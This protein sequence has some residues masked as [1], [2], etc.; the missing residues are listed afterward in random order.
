MRVLLEWTDPNTGSRCDILAED[1]SF[2]DRMTPLHKATSG[3]RFLGVQLLL[4]ALKSRSLLEDGLAALDANGMTPLELARK[5]ALKQEEER[6]GVR[7]WDAIAGGPAD[8]ERCAKILQVASSSG[9]AVISLQNTLPSHLSG[10]KNSACFDC[11][12]DDGKCKTASWEAAFRSALA[13][14]AELMESQAKSVESTTAPSMVSENIGSCSP[15]SENSA[16]RTKV[17]ACGS[18]QPMPSSPVAMGSKCS[19][20]GICCLSLFRGKEGS[21]V[22]K[23]CKRSKTC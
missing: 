3:G 22:C 2:G 21:L 17:S 16:T 8:W 19:R 7:R 18:V 14:S 13:S 12:A 10:V 11:S 9:E 20:C 1:S 4:D 23:R 6:S 15:G 5:L